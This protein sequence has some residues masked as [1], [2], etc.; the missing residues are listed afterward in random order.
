MQNARFNFLLIN[1]DY[2]KCLIFKK[3]KLNVTFNIKFNK[4]F[5]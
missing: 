4:R 1:R 3:Y 2:K 5:Y